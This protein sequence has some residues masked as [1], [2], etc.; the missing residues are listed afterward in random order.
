M[1]IP[2]TVRSDSTIATTQQFHPMQMTPFGLMEMIKYRMISGIN[3]DS[4]IIS[5]IYLIIV[6][7]FFENYH[8]II[9]YIKTFFDKKPQSKSFKDFKYSIYLNDNIEYNQLVDY[10]LDENK[11]KY[12]NDIYHGKLNKY[13]INNTIKNTVLN[14]LGFL[15]YG[16]E[17][18]NEIPF[19][20]KKLNFNN[21]IYYIVNKSQTINESNNY[22]IVCNTSMK[23]L[24]DFLQE[25]KT[26]N[27]NQIK[28]ELKIYIH[29]PPPR[30]V[31]VYNFST[32]KTFDNLFFEQKSQILDILHKFNNK[33]WYKKRGLPHHLGIL[34][35]GDPGT[36]KTSF[37]KALAVFMNKN[38]SY[39]NMKY[40]KTNNEF[41]KVINN[42][43]ANIIIFEDFDRLECVVDIMDAKNENK[44]KNNKDDKD[45]ECYKEDKNNN[46]FDNNI[47]IESLYNAYK[48][49]KDDV[50]K[51]KAFKVYKDELD[52]HEETK[53]DSLDL[54][55][56]LNV[57]DGVREYPE[58]IIIFTCNHPE[59]INN[60]LLRP[61]R[62]DIILEL[63][64]VNRKILDEII[65]HYYEID[66]SIKFNL[67]NIEE[68]K[69]TPAEIIAICKKY[70]DYKN[71]IEELE[72]NVIKIKTNY[73]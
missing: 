19:P 59:R 69:Y 41:T 43:D 21:W 62:I 6:I 8:K 31:I 34:L 26:N 56:M 10:K 16:C 54:S 30:N 73:M 4:S 40:I 33:E 23:D 66:D 22:Y 15:N 32:N 29:H 17:I 27:K 37:I 63:K 65:R 28:K 9:P 7:L 68:Y 64:N 67:D 49:I 52:K 20:L 72:K 11:N 61:G 1:Q 51:K 48:E 47:F 12:L 71:V 44:N 50:E 39:I 14:Y 57:L 45:N 25:L 35:K 53:K 58:R 55:H 36:G 46:C 70:N 38:I 42:N 18:N 60:A 13:V 24:C 2:N 5:I 3:T